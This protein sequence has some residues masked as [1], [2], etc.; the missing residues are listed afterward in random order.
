[1][2]KP[3]VVRTNAQPGRAGAVARPSAALSRGGGYA[4]LD[5]L[6]GRE[7]VF[8]RRHC[9]EKH[10]AHRGEIASKFIDTAFWRNDPD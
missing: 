7:D 1:M 4:R 9:G 5:V 10:V 8:E 2:R 3:V 6:E